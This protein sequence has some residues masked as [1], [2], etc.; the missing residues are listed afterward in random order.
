MSFQEWKRTACLSSQSLSG[1]PTGA[2]RAKRLEDENFLSKDVQGCP[3]YCNKICF[4]EA[5]VIVL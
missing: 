4:G 3:R 2:W 5:T 1:G